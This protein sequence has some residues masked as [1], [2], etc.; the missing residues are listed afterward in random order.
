[1]NDQLH[2]KETFNL[3]PALYNEI[4]PLYPKEILQAAQAYAALYPASKIAE[5]GPGTGQAS[6]FF[7]THGYDYAG[8]DLGADMVGFCENRFANYKNARFTV[9]T[10]E[11]WLPAPESF[12]FIFSAQAFHWIEPDYGLQKLASLLKPTGSIALIWNLDESRHTEFWKRGKNLHKVHVPGHS[13]KQGTNLKKS[14]LIFADKLKTS[15]L[16]Q[17]LEVI[18]HDWKKTYT[19]EEWIKMRNTFSQDLQL[20]EAQRNAF[21]TELTKIIND[22]GGSFERFYTT[23]CLLARRKTF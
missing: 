13:G 20:T 10:F 15:D 5:I 22:L 16:F 14:S 7:I 3:V 17:D 2:L 9:S 11:D 4:R 19:A 1:M 6:E 18:K 12:D 21:H 23:V 8:I